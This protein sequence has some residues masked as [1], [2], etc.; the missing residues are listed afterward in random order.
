MSSNWEYVLLSLLQQSEAETVDGEGFKIVIAQCVLIWKP[1]GLD[2]KPLCCKCNC[3]SFTL[4]VSKGQGAR[5]ETLQWATGP[6][7]G[8][9]DKEERKNREE[10]CRKSVH[11]V[12]S[13]TQVLGAVLFQ[14]NAESHLCIKQKNHVR[15][16][17]PSL[18]FPGTICSG[19]DL[20]FFL[21]NLPP[22]LFRYPPS[23][24]AVVFSKERYLKVC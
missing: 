19:S 5:E 8:V 3:S 10:R 14:P 22:R 1:E 16:Y 21:F 12:A 11:M 7:E 13:D 20:Y 24:F 23:L 2:G 15:K 18:F 6:R 9:R 4:E 17:S